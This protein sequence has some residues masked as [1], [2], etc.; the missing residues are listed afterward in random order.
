FLDDPL[1]G[2]Q[3]AP[4]RR[5]PDELR[6]LDRSGPLPRS[7]APSIGR[8]PGRGARTAGAPPL[9]AERARLLR[10]AL[11]LHDTGKAET[12]TLGEDGE[13]HFFMH[14]RASARIARSVLR[15]LRASRAETQ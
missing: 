1:A 11:L 4:P 10:W 3:E 9:S 7:L 14:E 5:D 6:T 12:R 15:R 2:A 8:L 13:Y